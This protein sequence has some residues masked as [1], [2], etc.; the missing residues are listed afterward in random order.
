MLTKTYLRKV[1]LHYRM[2]IDGMQYEQR[3][4]LLCRAAVDFI[5]NKN[6]QSLHTFLSIKKNQEPDISHVFDLLWS[7]GVRIVVSKTDFKLKQM[8]HYVLKV[9]T[10][11]IENTKG[12]PEPMDAEEAPLDHLDLIFVPLLIC[13][14][15]GYRIGY[16][17]GYY[18][19]LLLETKA[20]KVGLSLSPP[21]DIILQREDWDIPLDYLIT[22]FKTYNYG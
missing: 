10:K 13:D 15:E 1:I 21:V 12:I 3:N 16:G 18:D 17:G 7:K 19:R 9:E 20:L 6:I 2:L 22:P 14:K 4:E 11:L 8:R 5:E